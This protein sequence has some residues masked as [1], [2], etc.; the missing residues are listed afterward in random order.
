M[1]DVVWFNVVS[2]SVTNSEVTSESLGASASIT[3][4]GVEV[5]ASV[6]E[7]WSQGYSLTIGSDAVFYGGI[8][9]MPD[10]LSTP[11]DEYAGNRY[12]TTPWIYVD[13]WTD[14]SGNEASFMVMTYSVGE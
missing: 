2:E 3:A 11:E 9:P 5:G 7:G 10:R 13:H 12:S 1:G 6:T 8:P 4:F 14:E